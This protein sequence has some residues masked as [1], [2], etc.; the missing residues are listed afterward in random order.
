MSITRNNP[1][2]KVKGA[3]TQRGEDSYAIV[4]R[5]PS[6][7]ITADQLEALAQ[8]IRKYDIPIAKLTSGQRIALVGIKGADVPDVWASLSMGEGRAVKHGVHYVQA[9][10]G[11]AAC[12]YGQQDSLGLG[13]RLEEMFNGLNLPAKVKVGISGCPMCCGESYVRDIGLVGRKN[14]WTV[15]F[16]GNAGGRP[17]VG[18][19]LASGLD[20]GQ[21]L[22]LVGRVLT[23]YRDNAKKC[24]R[25]ARF[26][27]AKG[28]ASVRQAL[29]L[30]EAR[31][32]EAKDVV[33]KP[34]ETCLGLG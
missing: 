21:A 9:C 8:A 12:G 28:I 34:T 33:A 3:I 13:A 29:G 24:Q 16:G 10:P 6:G 25:T 7:V 2:P 4:P 20:A 30:L 1:A 32:A 11:N 19:E 26:V 27:E 31:A 23:H 14:G 18:D 15:V 22:D 17:R 5:L